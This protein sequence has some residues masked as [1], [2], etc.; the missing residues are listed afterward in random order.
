VTLSGFEENGEF[1]IGKVTNLSDGATVVLRDVN[2][3]PGWA[4]RSRKG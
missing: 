4:G 1:M 2:G 3:R